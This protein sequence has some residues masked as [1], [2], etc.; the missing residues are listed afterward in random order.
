MHFVALRL[1]INKDW[2][3]PYYFWHMFVQDTSIYHVLPSIIQGAIDGYIKNC[4][5]QKPARGY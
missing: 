5:W 4:D 2:L 3:K 1:D